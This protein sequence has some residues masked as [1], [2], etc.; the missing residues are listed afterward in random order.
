MDDVE[1]LVNEAR[2]VAEAL[3]R[4]ARV[5]LAAG[6]NVVPTAAQVRE[7]ISVLE[8]VEAFA[9]LASAGDDRAYEEVKSRIRQV[10]LMAER[11]GGQPD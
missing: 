10:R 7:A 1:V 2:A 4:R 11:L 5:N 3:A 8:D 9:I 6:A